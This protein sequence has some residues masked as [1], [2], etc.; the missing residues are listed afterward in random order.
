MTEPV[1]P[2]RATPPTA[3]PPRHRSR[4]KRALTWIAAS[5]AVVLVVTAVGGYLVYRHLSGNI[6]HQKIHVLGPR[7]SEGPGKSQN[8]LLMGS[9]TRAFKG[10]AKY[11][12]EVA[13]A[14]SDTTILVHISADGKKAILVSIPRDTY[15]RIPP[16]E[17]GHGKTS[18]PTM[19]RFNVAFS[20]GGPSCTIA[21]VEHLTHLRID[22]FVEVNFAGF[23]RMVDALGGVTV[24][25]SHP[26]DDP[27]RT[28]PYTGG[29]I[30][31][32]LVIGAGTHQ[33]DGTQALGFVRSRYAVGD[34]SDLGR[35]KNQQVFLSAMI[36]KATSTGLL[37]HPLSLYNFLDAAT[38][39]IRT[40]PG[41][42]LPQLKTLAGELHGLKPGK[43]SLLTVPL[44]NSNAY[45]TIGGL[46]A[47]V[48]FW[49]KARADALWHAL[50]TDGPLPGS[51]PKTQQPGGGPQLIV[52]PS[53]IHV[54]VLNGTGENGLAHKVASDLAARGFVID[55]V[56]DADSASYSSSVVRYG[57]DRNESSQ[58]LAASV[59]GSTRQ[60]DG[61]L[62]STVELIVGKDY[63][64]T[65]AVTISSPSPTPTKSLDVVTAKND[66]CTA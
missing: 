19:N 17:L 37:F 62:G 61:A 25:L 21:T 52:P 31:S 59:P 50:A 45:V 26:I 5:L 11:G 13:G 22:H 60:P 38:K 39:S 43:V 58:T 20:I 8:I 54:R 3:V 53:Q 44:S 46:R 63:A 51:Q 23:Q 29:K 15:T 41:F 30:G 48:V 6:A 16:C 7:P 24:C 9:D 10:G 2:P 18:A 14:R 42:G 12:A 34:G 47:S 35:I 1:A 32:G 64:G 55:G 28:N 66:V 56:G 27:V 49:D 57:V 40:D 65:R 36:R 4:L 33:L